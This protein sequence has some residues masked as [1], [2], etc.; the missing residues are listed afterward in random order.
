[1]IPIFPRSPVILY[2]EHFLH[3]WSLQVVKLSISC[4][5]IYN[6][7]SKSDMGESMQVLFKIIFY[8]FMLQL[9][10]DSMEETISIARSWLV[11]SKRKLK[12]YQQVV[13]C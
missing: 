8:F 5:K 7:V 13:D 11:T 4:H 1:M 10:H 12:F 9:L 3:L 2:Q 6:S